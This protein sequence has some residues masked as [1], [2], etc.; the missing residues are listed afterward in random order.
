MEIKVGTFYKTRNGRKARIYALDGVP[1]QSEIH[2]AI[3]DPVLEKWGNITWFSN[4]GFIKGP[5]HRLDIVSE[6]EE[7][8]PKLKAWVNE[9]NG[10]VELNP[11]MSG[12]N[13]TYWKRAPWLDEPDEQT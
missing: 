8:K 10:A 4:G 12:R 2:G 3:T 6:W 5:D 1:L 9:Q 13:I 11:E 7:P